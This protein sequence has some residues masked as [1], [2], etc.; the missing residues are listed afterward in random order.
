[1]PSVANAWLACALAERDA[2]AAKTALTVAGETA[3]SDDIVQ[4]NRPFVQGMVALMMKDDER[5]RSAFT[6]ARVEQEKTVKAQPNY[7][8]PLCEL[9]LID[10]ALG[11][12]VEAL[13]EARRAVELLP[14]EKDAINGPVVIAYSAMVAAWAGDKN[15]ACQQLGAAIRYPSSLSYG[16]LKLLPFWDPLRGDPR[17]KKIVVSLA[18]KG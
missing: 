4:L 10:A 17:F 5:A 12:K 18:P 13:G 14:V 9:G 1:L 11:R 15:L 3:W 16:Q 7:A 8:A 6:I 2:A